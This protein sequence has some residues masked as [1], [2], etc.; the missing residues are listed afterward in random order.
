MSGKCSVLLPVENTDHTLQRACN[1]EQG[2]WKT[3]PVSRC[4]ATI[5]SAVSSLP[6]VRSVEAW[7][8]GDTPAQSSVWHTSL[9]LGHYMKSRLQSAQE[10][11]F[12][13]ERICH[14]FSVDWCSWCK[15][16]S[17]APRM[18]A[19]TYFIP[20]TIRAP[21]KIVLGVPVQAGSFGMGVK[22]Q[23]VPHVPSGGPAG[24]APTHSSIFLICSKAPS[25]IPGVVLPNI[26]SACCHQLL[27]ELGHIFK[28]RVSYLLAGM[29]G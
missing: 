9:P 14:H 12:L 24:S 29:W 5:C 1:R 13:E 26:G 22:V 7:G 3:W 11:G 2:P 8:T 4:E 18:A 21:G 19:S 17:M 28:R 6:T 23:P 27:A 20:I 10:T 15:Q 25:G 16:A